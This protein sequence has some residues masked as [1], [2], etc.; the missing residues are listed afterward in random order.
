MSLVCQRSGAQRSTLLQPIAAL[1]MMKD[2]RTGLPAAL[3]SKGQTPFDLA[4]TKLKEEFREYDRIIGSVYSHPHW[5]D[6]PR[7][8][9]LFRGMRL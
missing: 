7:G 1:A 4:T 2:G 8:I 6:P 5:R 9:A 3:L